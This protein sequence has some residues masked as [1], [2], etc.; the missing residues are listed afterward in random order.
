[1]TMCYIIAIFKPRLH[2]IGLLEI[3]SPASSLPATHG[4]SIEIHYDLQCDVPH[5]LA[6]AAI[7]GE[8]SIGFS[9]NYGQIFFITWFWGS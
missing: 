7:F 3:C 4:I 5:A 6:S 9:E 8:L 1:M 2:F